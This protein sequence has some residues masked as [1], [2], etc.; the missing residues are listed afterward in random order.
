M[1]ALPPGRPRIPSL[2]E[3]GDWT[4]LEAMHDWEM[5]VGSSSAWI[6]SKMG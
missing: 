5:A 6:T 2:C 1:S 4:W 3:V